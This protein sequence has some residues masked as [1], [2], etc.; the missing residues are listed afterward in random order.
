ME[1]LV[2]AASLFAIVGAGVVTGLLFAF[3]NFVMTALAE[4]PDEVG[5]FAMQRINV[6]IINPVFLAF[7]LGTPIACA[8]VMVGWYAGVEVPRATLVG[9][10]LYACGP[11]GITMACNVPWNNRLASV[12]PA[13]SAAIWPV[14]QRRWQRWNHLRTYVGILAIASM[15]YGAV[16]P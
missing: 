7:F 6:H 1:S 12:D 10:G 8:A 14:Y 3:S 16:G 2:W 5:M 4:L 13:G 15:A 11:F 9:V